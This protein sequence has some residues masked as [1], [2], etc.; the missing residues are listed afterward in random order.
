MTL[1]PQIV[2]SALAVR[3][4][5]AGSRAELKEFQDAQLRR[6]VCHAYASV[7]FYRKLFDRHRL[8]PR[9]IRGTVDLDLIP[10]TSKQELRWQPLTALTDRSLNVDRLL[11]VW[12][13][14]STG[15]PFMVRRT[16]LEQ[17]FNV[18]FRDRYQKAYG[19]GL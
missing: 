12:T 10:I 7:P 2:R 18:L 15:G 5:A 6:L 3:R 13:S 19:L 16:W 11:T 14:G 1:G 4:H 17:G 9:H 8:H